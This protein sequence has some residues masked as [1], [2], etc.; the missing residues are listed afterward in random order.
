MTG[1]II[2]ALMHRIPSELR[3]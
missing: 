3:S 2:P 1:A